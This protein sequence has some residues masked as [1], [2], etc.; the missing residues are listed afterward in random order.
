MSVNMPRDDAAQQAPKRRVTFYLPQDLIRAVNE[1]AHEE[2][3]G[4]TSGRAF[5]PSAV[6]E[7]ILSAYFA[8]A[9]RDRKTPNVR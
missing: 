2:G 6:V 5:N 1:A 8:S 7:R 4:A 3:R 9:N